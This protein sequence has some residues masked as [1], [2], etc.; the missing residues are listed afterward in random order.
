ME[1]T[2]IYRVCDSQ[3]FQIAITTLRR[4]KVNISHSI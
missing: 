3:R 2:E 1:I 4:Y